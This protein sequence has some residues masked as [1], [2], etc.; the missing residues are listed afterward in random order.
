MALYLKCPKCGLNFTDYYGEHALDADDV[1]GDY[2]CPKCGAIAE[3]V[4]PMKFK[5]P[6][7]WGD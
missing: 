6:I 3:K 5:R 4:V 7:D 2:V 1:N